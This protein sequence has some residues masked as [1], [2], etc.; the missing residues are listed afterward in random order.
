MMTDPKTY[1]ILDKGNRLFLQGKL[2][3]A[4][5][6]FNKILNEKPITSQFP[7]Q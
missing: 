4:I 5:S 2:S 3:E 7:Q 1:S 6:Y